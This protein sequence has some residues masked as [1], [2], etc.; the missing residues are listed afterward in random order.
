MFPL[1]LTATACGS[2]PGETPR[3]VAAY[4]DT[5]RCL[6]A[7]A[8]IKTREASL[9]AMLDRIKAAGFNAIVSLNQTD[10]IRT[11]RARQTGHAAADTDGDK[12][13][14]P[15]TSIVVATA[16]S[17]AAARDAA[18]F[19]GD[20]HGDQD[21]INA[22][23]EALPLVGG[24]VTLMEGTYDIRQIR[25]QLGGVLIKR[26]NVT[27]AGQGS[28]TRLIQAPNQDTN[29]IRIIGSGVHHVTIRDLYVDAN[30]DQNA[31]GR[32]DPNVSHGRF[33]FCGIKGYYRAPGGPTGDDL[34]AITIRNC[35]IRNAHRLG[36]M[37]EGSNLRVLDNTLGNAGSDAVELLTGPG[38]IRGNYVEIT[39]QTHVAVGSDR[40]SSITMS[41]N[42]VRVRDGGK[43]D[44]GFRSWSNSQ[45][46]VV[47]NN[48][49]VVDPGGTCGLA[50]DMRGQM[51]TITGNA[52][53]S[54]NVD[55]PT[56]IRIGGGNT[57]LNGNLF[58]NVV[59]EIDDHYEGEKP[60]VM[61]GNVLD[62]TRVD[63]IR[64]NLLQ[65]PAVGNGSER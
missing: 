60:I 8:D 16:D 45:R 21:E 39:G 22:A 33:E 38:E 43:L 6:D 1:L 5:N 24:T 53:E 50:L 44:I 62:S 32:G 35:E 9:A 58:K 4:L 51:Q 49:L 36:V 18:D 27:L 23:I 15:N 55:H 42:I 41:N 61:Q 28:S 3:L 11:F 65:S 26:S 63:H 34:R 19:V 56:R 25:D 7:G 20:G 40:G 47:S 14:R 59:V 37:L 64:G 12:S 30:R 13:S 2:D 10:L 46:H 31:S 52:I 54:L 17:S 29:V 57:V 48:V